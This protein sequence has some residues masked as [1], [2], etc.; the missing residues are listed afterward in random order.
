ML[1]VGERGLN[2]AFHFRSLLVDKQLYIMV[3]I[4]FVRIVEA[5]S[6]I[7]SLLNL[8]LVNC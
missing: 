2:M 1:G 7:P 5:G 8:G 3:A 6:A 4:V